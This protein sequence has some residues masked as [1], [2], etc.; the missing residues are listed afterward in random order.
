MTMNYTP[1]YPTDEQ[2]ALASSNFT[3]ATPPTPEPM[4]SIAPS[5][6]VPEYVDDGSM[7]SHAVQASVPEPVA[8]NYASTPAP[9]GI[10]PEVVA[11][12]KAAVAPTAAPKPPVA[13]APQASSLQKNLANARAGVDKAYDEQRAAERARGEAEKAANTAK[14]EFYENEALRQ[15][16]EK[17]ERQREYTEIQNRHDAYLA[18]SDEMVNDLQNQKL[19]AGR[20]FKTN[21]VFALGA[22][23][24]GATGGRDGV[25]T[26]LQFVDRDLRDQQSAIDSKKDSIRARE[27]VYGQMRAQF[28]DKRLADENFRVMGLEAAKQQLAAIGAKSSNPQVQAKVDEQIAA[29]NQEQAKR[30]EALAAEALRLAQQQAAAARAQ[31]LA[32]QRYN[33]ERTDKERDYQLKLA[34]AKTDRIKAEGEA[35]IKQSEREY[36]VDGKSYQASSPKDAEEIKKAAQFRDAIRKDAQL[37]K[38][39]R[40]EYGNEIWDR[41]ALARA[42]A[43]ASRLTLNVKELGN[44]G[45]LSGSDRELTEAQVPTNP[46]SWSESTDGVNTRMDDL[47]SSTDDNFQAIV[48][49]RTKA[50]KSPAVSKQQLNFKKGL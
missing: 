3:P 10:P 22:I 30:K 47:L 34:G 6:P 48:N 20:L 28:G 35:G 17:S 14:A 12:A 31:Q 36:T 8:M 42:N 50:G 23:L 26:V 13:A 29:I 41:A 1:A 16:W 4:M 46:L 5:V 39:L 49:A 37:L 7:M 19:D 18:K 9:Q 21:P 40:K 27:S 2:F 24:V 15:A 38:D 45:A 25:N 44:L 33:D 32:T 43:A 11:R